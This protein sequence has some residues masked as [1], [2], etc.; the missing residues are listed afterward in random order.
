MGLAWYAPGGEWQGSGGQNHGG[1]TSENADWSAGPGGQQSSHHW[2]ARENHDVIV[3]TGK[4][5]PGPPGA[6]SPP[7]ALRRA[8]TTRLSRSGSQQ[9]GQVN[10]K[11]SQLADPQVSYRPWSQAPEG[12]HRKQEHSHLLRKPPS[13]AGRGRASRA[14]SSGGNLPGGGGAET[15]GVSHLGTGLGGT[16]SQGR[17]DRPV[18][19]QTR[20]HALN[21][22]G[23]RGPPA[24]PGLP[25]Q[26]PSLL[27]LAPGAHPGASGHQELRP[28]Q[29]FDSD[30]VCSG[31]SPGT[32]LKVSPGYRRGL[33]VQGSP[34]RDP[35]VS[36]CCC[37]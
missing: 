31:R 37:C 16:R 9:G 1:R 18:W 19:A 2:G 4:G 14:G 3:A 21:V 6:P 29:V 8:W 25:G 23:R 33:T 7:T 12:G 28:L 15:E 17:Q 22:G 36:G 13:T 26:S 27:P 5:K 30:P 20:H 11:V 35:P 34:P 10:T 32:D 24:T